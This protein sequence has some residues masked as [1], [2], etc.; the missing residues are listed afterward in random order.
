MFK[1]AGICLGT[2]RDVLFCEGLL[3]N[4]PSFYYS[5]V[6]IFNNIFGVNTTY[7]MIGRHNVRLTASF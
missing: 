5:V 3:I 4:F 2:S 1:P 6:A 7:A